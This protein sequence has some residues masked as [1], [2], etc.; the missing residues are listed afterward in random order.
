MSSWRFNQEEEAIRSSWESDMS[1]DD[2][3]EDPSR[4]LATNRTQQHREHQTGMEEQSATG[5]N[6]S[7]EESKIKPQSRHDEKDEE[8]EKSPV[9]NE[10]LASQSR[11]LTRR[12]SVQER[13]SMFEN[14]Q[15]ENSG[16]KTAL[17]KSTELKRLSSDLSSSA[18][19]EK[20]VVR[21]WSG[22]SDM[23]IDLGNDRKDGTGDSPLCTPSS[24][25]VSKDGSGISSKQFVGYN[26]KEQNGLSHTEN[27]H[28]NEEECSSK[29]NNGGDWGMD[30]V[31]SHNSS[32]TFLLKDKEV[33]LKPL[34]SNNQVGRKGNSQ[35]GFLEKN[36]RGTLDYSR[37]T[38]KNEESDDRMDDY[39]SN[40]PNQIQFRDPRLGGTEPII[41]SVRSNGGS[42]E[43]PRKELMP[44]DRQSPL[45]EDRQR[46][47][48]VYG[49]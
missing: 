49:G 31:E 29:S 9:Q 27:S 10:P 13:I 37:N 22:A 40:R 5:F 46:K 47:T 26:K 36:S 35:D 42:E 25:P 16:G 34:S 41:T 33:D 19:M 21:R 48:P 8:E 39:E 28:R 15:K 17:G 7:P 23:S 45:V 18:G 20:V 1:I 32:S 4:N 6:Y 43:S 24:L 38:N 2:T 30:E 14:K 44:S 12:L 3:S 11:Q